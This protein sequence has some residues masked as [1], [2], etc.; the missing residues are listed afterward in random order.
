MNLDLT[1]L[2]KECVAM[3]V[4]ELLPS[5]INEIKQSLYPAMLT[6]NTKAA[7]L[8]GVHP[9]TIKNRLKQGDYCEGVHYKRN[10]KI[11]TWY[12]DALL[13]KGRQ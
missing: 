1:P 4:K 5:V 9:N 7:R 6:G 3:A 8:L 12:R 2:V 10:G 11:L 13:P